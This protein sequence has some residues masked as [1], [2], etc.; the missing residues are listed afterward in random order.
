MIREYGDGECYAF[1]V[2]PT[3]NQLINTS[4]SYAHKKNSA[5]TQGGASPGGAS[6][7]VASFCFHITH[8]VEAF[9]KYLQTLFLPEG[10]PSSVTDDLLPSAKMELIQQVCGSIPG[11]LATRAILMGIGVGAA[12][13]NASS[14]TISWV[15]RDGVRLV[16]SIFFAGQVSTD[17]DMRSKSWRMIADFCGDFSAMVEVVGSWFPP[18]FLWMLGFAAC[19]KAI[20][21]V[22]ALG[23]RASF[24]EHFAKIG[25]MADVT[26]KANNREYAAGFLGLFL[27][28]L[29]MYCTPEDSVSITLMVFLFFTCL[30]LY[31]NYYSLRVHIM[32]HLNGPRMEICLSTFQKNADRARQQALEKEHKSSENN[33]SK[34]D[35]AKKVC[36]TPIHTCTMTQANNAE[37]LFILPPPSL[38][39]QKKGFLDYAMSTLSCILPRML[40]R[41]RIGSSLSEA[42]GTPRH[43]HRKSGNYSRVGASSTPLVRPED[44]HRI[45]DVLSCQGVALLYNT[46]EETYYVLITEY[47]MSQGQPGSWEPFRRREELLQLAKEGMKDPEEVF[48]QRENGNHII[49]PTGHAP[50]M[51]RELWGCF[52]AYYHYTAILKAREGKGEEAIVPEKGEP[53]GTRSPEKRETGKG[54]SKVYVIQSLSES[55]V[56]NGNTQRSHPFEFDERTAFSKLEELSTKE[57]PDDPL[58]NYFILF[59][60]SLKRQGYRLDRLLLPNEGHTISIEYT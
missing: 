10:Y 56:F 33:V 36:F 41:I 50:R 46:W 37:Y 42:Y 18:L 39:H 51:I 31:T 2:S 3:T 7:L 35:L 24:S 54:S 58:Y 44:I 29:T 12:T 5:S 16:A 19:L 30:H 43:S 47:F 4:R 49:I 25:N 17:L 57:Y 34:D 38:P 45:S 1:Q 22:C 60:I 52:Y 23:T 28:S 14:S 27:G 32:D 15:M 26:T 8:R 20:V 9:R 59:F 6:S 13:A 53:S 48:Q 40:L 11:A 55:G 21:G